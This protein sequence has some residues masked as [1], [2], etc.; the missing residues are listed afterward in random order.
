MMKAKVTNERWTLDQLMK[1]R[2][3]EVLPQWPTGKDVADLDECVSYAKSIPKEKNITLKCL[4]AKKENKLLLQPQIGRATLEDTLGS[5][6]YIEEKTNIAP[7][8]ILFLYPDS[9]T[10]KSMYAQAQIGLDRSKKE[11]KTML[12]GWPIV[13]YGVEA[14]RKIV[15]G[16]KSPCWINTADEDSRLI[17]EIS[18][19]SGM[20]CFANRHLQEVIAH[21]KRIPLDEMIRLSQYE[22]RLAAHYTENGVPIAGSNVTHLT[23]Y[24]SAGYRTVVHVTQAIVA[25]GQGVKYQWLGHA[26]GMNMVQDIAEIRVTER[27]A[28]E[29]CKRFGFN[30]VSFWNGIFPFLGAWPQVEEE[31]IAMI[32]WNAIIPIMGGVTIAWLKCID[33]AWATPTK[34]GMAASVNLVKH[35]QQIMGTQRMPESDSLALEERMI[36]LEARAILDKILEL[37]DGDI[38]AAL[39][40]GVDAG[41]IDTMVTPWIHNKGRVLSL[42]DAEGAV[43]YYDHGNLPLPKEVIEYH[44]EKLAMREKK[45]GKKIDLASVIKDI[46]MASR[47]SGI[48]AC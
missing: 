9:Y 43:R 3:E 18:F 11:G 12:N 8:G 30:D 29:Y 42:R 1:V 25:A 7:D 17:C 19:A 4:E 44:K 16:V 38:V 33:E 22:S 13:N 28:E 34:E 2:K 36:E 32:A 41:V 26:L 37:G 5:L 6:Q 46:K 47:T 39:C 35:L 24:D 14:T 10:R 15:K 20:T 23:G 21:C 45:Q 27:L 48:G 31:A 40:K